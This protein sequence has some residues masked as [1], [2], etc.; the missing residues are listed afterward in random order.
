MCYSAGAASAALQRNCLALAWHVS[1][2][3][4]Q[5]QF[6]HYLSKEEEV[7]SQPLNYCWPSANLCIYT[8]TFN[9]KMILELKYCSHTK[10]M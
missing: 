9:T 10:I 8:H 4:L 3:G 7:S 6:K 5:D 2:S 1:C